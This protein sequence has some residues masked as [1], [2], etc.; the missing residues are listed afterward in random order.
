MLSFPFDLNFK[1][2]HHVLFI[3]VLKHGGLEYLLLC[4]CSWTI[5]DA[6]YCMRHI[7]CIRSGD[8]SGKDT[9]LVH[10]TGSLSGKGPV[11]HIVGSCVHKCRC[12]L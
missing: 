10:L 1:M 4:V 9:T 5:V 12:M 2:Q 8:P 6:M 3:F 7:L 11:T